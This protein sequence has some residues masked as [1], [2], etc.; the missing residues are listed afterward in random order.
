MTTAVE[1]RDLSP[2]EGVGRTAEP[3]EVVARVLLIQRYSE[4]FGLTSFLA[5]ELR[6]P[7]LISRALII[8]IRPVE[9]T[10]QRLGVIRG[11]RYLL[12]AERGDG[13]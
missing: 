10:L 7:R 9:W 5:R 4:G 11:L 8:M 12:L 3:R 1:G 13:R 6:A 2:F